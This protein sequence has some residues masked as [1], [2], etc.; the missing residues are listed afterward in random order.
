[1]VSV[2][3][4]VF[5]IFRQVIGVRELLVDI[6]A[7]STLR[8]FLLHLDATYGPAYARKTGRNLF[9]S[10]VDHFN[11]FLNNEALVLP[12]RLDTILKDKDELKII[13]PSGGG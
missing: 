10:V 7:R 5:S 4:N 8:D 1:M 3:L 9:D 11:V 6:T 13:R 12:D 2:K